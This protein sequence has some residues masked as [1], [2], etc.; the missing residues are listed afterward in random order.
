M[1]SYSF[2]RERV[3]TNFL[4]P[5]YKAEGEGRSLKGLINVSD[6]PGRICWGI[7]DAEDKFVAENQQFAFNPWTGEA[8]P[9]SV[10]ALKATIAAQ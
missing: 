4:R 10:D 3:E 5:R 1:G 9:E 2:R 7:V 6:N 8:L